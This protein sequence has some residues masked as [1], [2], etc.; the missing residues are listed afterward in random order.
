MSGANAASSSPGPGGFEETLKD[1]W[2][3]RPR[4]PIHGRKVAGVAAG[5][6]NRYGIDPVLVRVAFVTATIFGGAGVSLYLL[7]WLLFPGEYDEVS[8]IEALA[9]HHRSSMSKGFTIALI[10]LFFPLTSWAFAGG[11]FSGGGVIGLAMLVT[12]LY[13]LHRSRGQFNRPVAPVVEKATGA[14]FSMSSSAP[15]AERSSSWDPLGAAP[16]GW[17]LP[18]PAPAPTPPP[19]RKP[20]P[21]RRRNSAVGL[22]T[23]AVALVV[24]GVGAAL[25]S[26][27]VTWF[28]VQHIIGL[29]LGVLGVGMVTGAFLNGGRGLIG[30]AIPLSIAGLVTTAVPISDY[31]GGYGNITAVPHTAA[32]VQRVYQHTA[33]DIDLDLTRLDATAPVTTDVRNGAGNTTVVVPANADVRYSCQVQ[34][35]NVDCLGNQSDG[36]GRAAVTGTDLGP[37]GVGGPQIT[38]NIR[39]A[40][41]SVEVRRD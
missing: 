26:S 25:G 37:D 8:P 13:L 34:A 29:A 18:D 36:V 14:A 27:G 39:Q 22:A 31:T 2:A 10:V 11:W 1:F 35:G 19:P 4:R 20:A 40:A 12:A 6:G 9:G 30:W 41:G 28:S 32:E 24:A 15:S 7:S 23:F 16:L 38:L 5:I 3:S 33:G 17:D 21:S